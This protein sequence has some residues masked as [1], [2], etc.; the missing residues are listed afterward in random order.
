MTVLAESDLLDL[1]SLLDLL[2]PTLSAYFEA[3][4]N[5]KVTLAAAP[6][7]VRSNLQFGDEL[8]PTSSGTVNSQSRNQDIIQLFQS[9]LDN[10][11]KT[12]SPR[13]LDKLYTGSD[14]IG[15]ASEL[16]LAILNTNSHVF[17]VS[18]VATLMEHECIA[19]LSALVGFPTLCSGIFLPG[20]SHSNLTAMTSARNLLYP[21][22]KLK[23]AVR[24]GISLSI[25]T[26]VESHYSIDKAAIALGLGLEGLIKLPVSGVGLGMDPAALHRAMI[27]SVENGDTPF[28]VNLTAGTTIF[29]TYDAIQECLN[30]VRAVEDQYGI[31]VWVHVDG[32]YGG[33]A[34]FS[35]THRKALLNGLE[36]VDSFT[37][38]PHKILGVP[39]QCS[40]LL[41]NSHRGN[42]RDALWRANGL[43]ADYLF[44]DSI[45]PES[46]AAK[47]TF[48][49]REGEEDCGFMMGLGDATIGCGRRTDSIKLYISWKYHGSLGFQKRVENA[50][51]SVDYLARKLNESP[52]FHL[53]LP[54]S[55]LPR[56]SVSFWCVPPS[57]LANYGSG[58]SLLES[59]S[60]IL[61]KNITAAVHSELSKRGTYMIDYMGLSSQ[62]LPPFLRV[63]MSHP[64]IDE[65]FVNGLVEELEGI[66]L[67]CR[68]TGE[69]CVVDLQ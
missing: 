61:L 66:V 36:C 65:S 44:H 60:S 40:L 10:S 67:T 28:F 8:T 48:K 25:F 55:S 37:I 57:I 59:Q 1:V 12:A 19:A 68:V 20:G 45:A 26:S 7:V 29:S 43:S 58:R 64:R 56:L 24:A 53:V 62:N 13:F 22:I 11:T 47:P 46:S 51:S 15:Q 30:V 52:Y 9:I 5:D 27:N 3:L 16:L 39:L 50:F 2:R 34:I 31:R 38:S 14:A 4:P 18:P 35:P 49:I 32:S 33:P 42:G 63:S 6:S 23:G 21:Q 54:L 17:S 69:D 41:V